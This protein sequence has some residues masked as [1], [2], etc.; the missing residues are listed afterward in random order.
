MSIL[1][2]VI[3]SSSLLAFIFAIPSPTF[4]DLS[5]AFRSFFTILLFR[6]CESF[7]GRIILAS[8]SRADL[9]HFPF[10]LAQRGVCSPSLFSGRLFT[11]S[12]SALMRSQILPVSWPVSFID[13]D[14][15]RLHYACLGFIG[16]EKSLLTFGFIVTWVN[17]SASTA[18]SGVVK[19]DAN[20]A[21]SSASAIVDV[22]PCVKVVTIQV[23]L[24]T[25]S[26]STASLMGEMNDDS[27]SL[28]TAI[29]ITVTTHSV[30]TIQ[31]ARAV[32]KANSSSLSLIT[33][34]SSRSLSLASETTKS[35]FSYVI[36]Y[37]E[38]QKSIIHGP[39]CQA[40][41]ITVG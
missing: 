6:R 15:P 23:A 24:A 32:P 11:N 8:A 29:I 27:T 1:C 13:R 28:S 5:S 16:H 12:C 40:G 35:S 30:R 2:I 10:L 37:N 4:F 31:L 20:R 7:S 33:F 14:V 19:N 41:F 39:I 17:H 3:F 25:P 9:I 38:T 34:A 21:P 36:P 22:T 26:S 18:S